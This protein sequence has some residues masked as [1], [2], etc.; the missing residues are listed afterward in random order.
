MKQRMLDI[1]DHRIAKVKNVDENGEPAKSYYNSTDLNLFFETNGTKDSKGKQVFFSIEFNE[2]T[3]LHKQLFEDYYTNVKDSSS[4][5]SEAMKLLKDLRND[6][7]HF[8][9]KSIDFLNGTEFKKLYSFMFEFS[10]ILDHYNMLPTYSV[11]NTNT[12]KPTR[13]GPAKSSYK[14]FVKNS[15]GVKTLCAFLNGLAYR[16]S[17]DP[18]EI[19]DFI[20]FCTKFDMHEIDVGYNEAVSLVAAMLEQKVLKIRKKGTTHVFNC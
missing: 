20:W 13:P 11:N 8:Y 7:T 18:F 6:E 19:V 10:S 2:L 9:V 5:I 16:G 1:N 4:S 14:D 15:A 12:L 3:Q 17:E